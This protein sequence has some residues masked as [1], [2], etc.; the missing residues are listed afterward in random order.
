MHINDILTNGHQ[1]LMHTLDRLS[2]EDAEI[3]NVCGEWSVKDILVHLTS[4]EEILGDLLLSLQGKAKDT[5]RLH[6]F[7]YDPTFNDRIVLENQHKSYQMVLQEYDLSH[8]RASRLLQAF[9]ED[10]QQ[11]T[12][13][14]AWYGADYDL[15]DFIAYT[16]YGHKV[17]HCAQIAIFIGGIT[18]ADLLEAQGA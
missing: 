16:Y 1:T 15:D 13:L 17:E 3:P 9:P 12:G 5:L 6:D 18:R 14:I 4:F 10:L 8:Q 11:Q 2:V 7:I